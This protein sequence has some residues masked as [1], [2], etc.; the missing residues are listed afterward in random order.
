HPET[1]AP[2]VMYL[3]D[4]C[5]G[6]D[7]QCDRGLADSP[8]ATL[9]LQNPAPSRYYVVVDTGS[10]MAVGRFRLTVNAV[11]PPQCR[12][13]RDNDGDGRVD[14]ADPG[15]TE[16]EDADE[17]DPDEAPVCFN[18]LDDD[19]DGLVDWPTDPDCVAAGGPEEAPPCSLNSPIARLGQ[20]GG[21]LMLP[22]LQGPGSAQARCEAGLGAETVIVLTLTDPSD[23]EFQVFTAAGMPLQSVLHARRVCE[24]Q[25]TEVGCRP[26]AR[27]ME[28][29]NLVELDRGTW[30]LFA[31]QGLVAP[32]GGLIAR[33][34]VQS[35]ITECNDLID[36]D[37]DG[38]IDVADPG[39]ERGRDDSERD[40]GMLP[41]CADGIDN[42]GNGVIDWPDDEGCVAAG[43]PEET[44]P[45]IS[46]GEAAGYGHHGS[47]NTW[48]AC[49]NAQTCAN[50]ACRFF[51]HGDAL[52]FREG[53]C[54]D[55]ARMIPG[56]RCSLFAALPNNLDANWGNGCNIPVA[57]DILCAAR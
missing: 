13:G 22:A 32:P 46:L 49:G 11:E 19:G 54:Q 34:M 48:N 33:V 21:E 26:G 56:F 36:N 38:L 39:C 17:V 25:E 41:Q 31:E 53:L 55:V 6:A 42:D 35:A 5:Q 57:Y 9:T 20:Q 15:C 10:R 23:V 43:D 16:S 37:G 3:R 29:L 40:P 8:G 4:T 51:G 28:P 14:L 44:P 30:F 2:V 27:A 1:E 18:D 7:R 12:D 47:C 52:E 24:D 45:G 50:A